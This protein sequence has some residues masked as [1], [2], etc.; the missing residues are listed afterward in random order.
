[1][2]N[3]S[4]N[5]KIISTILYIVALIW[6]DLVSKYLFYDLELLNN[7]FLPVANH[8]ISYSMLSGQTIYII[9][10]T[11]II[12]IATTYMYQKKIITQLAY[13]LV[14]SWWI[15]NL[16]D[17]LYYWFVRDFIYVGNRFP[18]FNVADVLIFFWCLIIFFI[19]W[20]MPQDSMQS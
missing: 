13:I 6:I 15:W 19:I 20:N 12:L 8:G 5:A 17:R 3:K 4:I 18:V 16:V 11:L 2:T 9:W 10:I 1:M 14:I 7:I